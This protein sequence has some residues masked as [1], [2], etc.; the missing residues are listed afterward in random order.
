[1]GGGWTSRTSLYETD[2]AWAWSVVRRA[3][4]GQRSPVAP[5][6]HGTEADVMV[7]AAAASLRCQHAAAAALPHEAGEAVGYVCTY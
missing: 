6:Y 3:T 4:D 7:A 5:S 1:M 2:A